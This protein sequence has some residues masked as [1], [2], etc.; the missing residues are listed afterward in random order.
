MASPTDVI[1]RSPNERVLSESWLCLAWCDCWI[2]RQKSEDPCLTL[3]IGVTGTLTV[4]TSRRC[5]SQDC[6]RAPPFLFGPHPST[7]RLALDE[8]LNDVRNVLV[9]LAPPM[10]PF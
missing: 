6:C 5:L 2:A 8:R 1:F 10:P 4:V 9:E 7:Q 3:G